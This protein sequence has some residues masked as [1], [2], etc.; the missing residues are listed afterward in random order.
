M[1][2]RQEERQRFLQ[3]RLEEAAAEVDA[4][5]TATSNT[6][7]FKVPDEIRT[8][9][10]ANSR[11]L[12]LR[13]DLRKNAQEAKREFDTRVGGPFPR[14]DC[15]ETSCEETGE[16][17]QRTCLCGQRRLD[18][19]GEGPLRKMLRRKRRDVRGA[20]G[21]DS[22]T[23]KMRRQSCFLEQLQARK[24]PSTGSCVRAEKMFVEQRQPAWMSGDRDAAKRWTD[25]VRGHPLVRKA[26]QGKVL[27]SRGF[28]VS[29]D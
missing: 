26:V 22:R 3:A 14:E 1:A 11:N 8:M 17:M 16:E 12:F 25:S 9:A 21:E 15:A 28:G 27:S 19:G 29:Y 6:N 5:T 24:L 18:G 23:T 2:D 10:A 4:R 7:K 20:S 13:K